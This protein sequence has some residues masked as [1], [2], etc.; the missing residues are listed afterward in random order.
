METEN[1]PP[2][3][4][5][6]TADIWRTKTNFSKILSKP[7]SGLQNLAIEVNLSQHWAIPE[8]IHTPPM[9]DIGNPVIN[10]Q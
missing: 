7:F 6:L 1:L 2:T 9:D 10:A 3:S 5:T 4:S 8:N